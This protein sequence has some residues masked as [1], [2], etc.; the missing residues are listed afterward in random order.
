MVDIARSIS[1][2]HYRSTALA[3]VALALVAV[4]CT[5]AD[6]PAAKVEVPQVEASV[7]ADDFCDVYT[8]IQCAGALG[9][10]A[11]DQAPFSSE[12]EC[13]Q[14]STCSA[15]LAAL[16]ASP[17]V[18][19]GTAA[20]D[21]EA[22]GAFLQAMAGSTSYCGES[23]DA[24]LAAAS[25]FM[26]GTLG[27]GEDCVFAIG[28]PASVNVCAPGLGCEIGEDPASGETL[29][30]CMA[31]DAVSGEHGGACEADEDCA[32]KLCNAGTCEGETTELFCSAPETIPPSNWNTVSTT[33]APTELRVS[34]HASSNSG[35]ADNLT[36]AYRN[37]SGTYSCTITTD[38]AD[39]ETASCTPTQ[40]STNTHSDYDYFYVKYTDKDNSFAYDDGLRA[41]KVTVTFEGASTAYSLTSF[42]Y[43]GS[44]IKCEGCFLGQDCNSCWL[45]GDGQGDC[46]ELRANMR[47]SEDININCIDHS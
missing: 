30:T 22:A 29:A 5:D 15:T 8:S 20:Y 36:L 18:V 34:A 42:T 12:A 2:R 11:A 24:M 25:S 19:D 9:C 37:K 17:S 32:S 39:G 14:A 47:S 3:L 21:P 16:L 31:A 35:T 13:A 6:E 44:G 38:I 23:D 26:V 4:G 33:D 41:S 1:P 27:E 10:C 40:S 45:D 7:S 46:L 43:S 28:D